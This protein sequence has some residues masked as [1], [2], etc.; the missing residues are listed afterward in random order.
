[1]D[2]RLKVRNIL[3]G[4][5]SNKNTVFL[6]ASPRKKLQAQSC[7]HNT[8]ARTDGRH[9]GSGVQLH[10]VEASVCM[11]DGAQTLPAA[12]HTNQNPQAFVQMPQAASHRECSNSCI[13]NNP[14][15]VSVESF[16]VG[17]LG[18]PRRPQSYPGMLGKDG[19][20]STKREGGGGG[21]SCQ[22]YID[23]KIGLS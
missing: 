6:V 21:G 14:C 9:S 16:F 4:K 19:S 22:R 2:F 10:Y 3:T 15:K 17:L 11:T 12:Q 5:L 7:I 20:K 18:K 1:M 23:I 13:D 8:L